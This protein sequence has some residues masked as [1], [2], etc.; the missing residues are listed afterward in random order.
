[1][2]INTLVMRVLMR[3]WDW[4]HSISRPTW[5]CDTSSSQ[6]VL[7][8]VR[9]S[10]HTKC[11]GLR[12]SSRKHSSQ[13]MTNSKGGLIRAA[14]CQLQ[15]RLGALMG[16]L[17]GG[18]WQAEEL[19]VQKEKSMFLMK[20]EKHSYSSILS[21]TKLMTWTSL[22][23]LTTLKFKTKILHYTPLCSLSQPEPQWPRA[24]IK[25]WPL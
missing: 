13:H 15:T 5:T 11:Q 8:T 23:N 16:V 3:S 7:Y 12:R 22:K 21:L 2:A 9:K 1:M 6:I 19:K 17:R 18:T 4:N 24:P 25:T 14:P 10:S 20:W